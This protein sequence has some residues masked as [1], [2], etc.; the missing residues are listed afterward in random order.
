MLLSTT[1]LLIR[2]GQTAGNESVGDVVMTGWTDLPLTELGVRQSLAVGERL[3]LEPAPVAL[4]SSPLERALH[5]AHCIRDSLAA[6]ESTAA[7]YATGS[8]MHALSVSERLSPSRPVVEIIPEPDLREIDCGDADGLTI[9]AVQGRY[10][11]HWARNQQQNDPNFRWPKGESYSEF[12]QRILLAL[13]RIAARHFGQRIV[14]VTHAGAIS[15]VLGWMQ[16][17][18]PARWESFRP[19]NAS[20]T[21]L[22]WV[23]DPGE[24]TPFRSQLLRL[25]RFDDRELSAQARHPVAELA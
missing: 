10:P 7:T 18:S 25:V 6:A 17:L 4:Y 11:Q 14:V 20:I 19:S 3:V 22:Q 1:L 2:H 8:A 23:Q 9:S 5:T 24:P 21:E 16:G 12:R 15:Q 13:S